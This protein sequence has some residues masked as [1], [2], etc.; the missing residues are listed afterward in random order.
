[1]IKKGKQK[2]IVKGRGQRWTAGKK[3]FKY[4]CH[5][6][7]KVGH[8]SNECQS[9]PNQSEKE[10]TKKA[11]AVSLCAVVK[12]VDTREEAAN[13]GTENTNWCLDSGCTAHLCKDPSKFDDIDR[14]AGQQLNLANSASTHVA[15]K[16][17]TSIQTE[18]EGRL[19]NVSV[20]DTLYVPDLR[21]NRRENYRQRIY[22]NFFE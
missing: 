13:L 6:C 7:Q 5:R 12:S 2:E 8:K 10:S 15:G 14:T 21:M 11:D 16:G 4:R 1:M 9:Q 18:T 22:R 3:T 20:A 19:K 17:T